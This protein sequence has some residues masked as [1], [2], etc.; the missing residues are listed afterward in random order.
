ML[1]AEKSLTLP[2]APNVAPIKLKPLVPPFHLDIRA[3]GQ[4]NDVE[5]SSS[6]SSQQITSK[7]DT[8]N[9]EN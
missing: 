4:S 6:K 1:S 2:N 9:E 5:N 7:K 3:Q 8:E